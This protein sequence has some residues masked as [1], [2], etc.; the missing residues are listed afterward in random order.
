VF[1]RNLLIYFD[2]D[3]QERVLATLTTLLAPRGTLVVGAADSFAVRRSGYVPVAGA[4][5]AFLFHYRGVESEPALASAGD[6]RRSIPIAV[7]R[8][9]RPPRAPSAPVRRAAAAR[10]PSPLDISADAPAAESELRLM[11]RFAD[12]GLF[13]EAVQVGEAA[14]AAAT[15]NADLLALLGTVHVAQGHDANAE[16]C[17]RRALYLDPGHADALLHL[18]L[19]LEGRGDA[20]GARRLRARARR[21]DADSRGIGA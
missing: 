1:C 21:S 13:S 20:D 4:E 11:A 3:A 5:R 9:G 10:A 18:A 7:P 16:R 6:M 17:Y 12:E 8:T 15:A 14:I 2:A 19:I